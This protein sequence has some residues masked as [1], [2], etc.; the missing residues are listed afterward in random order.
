[1]NS[2][3]MYSYGSPH[4]A[5]QK[6]DDQLERTFSSYVRI[7][8]VVLKTCLGRWTIGRSGERGSGMSVLPARYDDDDDDDLL[9]GLFVSASHQT[10]LD[11]RSMTRRSIIED[12]QGRGRS[13][14]SRGSSPAGLCWSS[15]HFV[16]CW[17]DEPSGTWTQIWVQARMPYYS[18]NWTAKSSTIQA[19]QRCQWCSSPTRR[20]P[21]RICRPFGLKS[22]F[23]GQC[24]LASKPTANECRR[25][26]SGT[27]LFFTES[28]IASNT[29]IHT[30]ENSKY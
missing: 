24:S 25:P 3:E 21:N 11:T 26:L 18:L 30:I 7:Q 17:P 12:I 16:Q 13:G 27:A 23:V 6:Q 22:A 4:M 28:S 2:I 8:V 1:M 20:W 10:G 5:S 19:W 9:C 29:L 14:T 15:A